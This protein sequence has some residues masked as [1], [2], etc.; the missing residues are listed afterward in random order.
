MDAGEVGLG[1]DQTKQV[2]P[3]Y[4]K[5]SYICYG[6]RLPICNGVDLGQYQTKQAKTDQA[7]PSFI[8]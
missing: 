1:Q 3:D 2:I 5:Q 8:C 4:A 6:H 7:A